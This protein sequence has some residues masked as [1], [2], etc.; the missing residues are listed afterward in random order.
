MDPMAD[1]ND[2]ITSYSDWSHPWLFY[3]HVKTRLAHRESSQALFEDVWREAGDYN[4][5]Q[6]TDLAACARA[7]ASAIREQFPNLSDAAVDAIANAV[8]YEWR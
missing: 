5:W 2:A 8:A 4:Y 6:S 3:D 7:A 1:V